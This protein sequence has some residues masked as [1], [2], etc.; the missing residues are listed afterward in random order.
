VKNAW[1]LSSSGSNSRRTSFQSS[2]LSTPCS[3]RSQTSSYSRAA[4]TPSRFSR[5]GGGSSSSRLE[6][7]TGSGRRR[8]REAGIVALGGSSMRALLSGED[9]MAALRY[10]HIWPEDRGIRHESAVTIQRIFRGHLARIYAWKERRKMLKYQK[11]NAIELAHRSRPKSKISNLKRAHLNTTYQIIARPRGPAPAPG[12]DYLH[13][14]CN[15][16]CSFEYS[17]V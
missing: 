14:T 2:Q 15:E 12:Q 8:A 6:A 11:E 1:R 17:L 7:W 10:G 5:S 9:E 4:S 16:I 13:I 3:A